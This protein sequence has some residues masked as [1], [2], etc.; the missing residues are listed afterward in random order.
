MTES[1]TNVYS[2][3]AWRPAEVVEATE[4]SHVQKAVSRAASAGQQVR[5]ISPHVWSWSGGVVAEGGVTIVMRIDGIAHDDSERVVVGAGVLL[6]DLHVSAARRGLQ[7]DAHGGCMTS[8]AS[9]TAGGAVATNVHHTGVAT[10][11]DRCTFVDIVREDST[12]VRAECG[13]ELWRLTVGGAGRTGVIVRVGFELGARTFYRPTHSPFHNAR[14]HRSLGEEFSAFC[15]AYHNVAPMQR[16]H[17][18]SV[19]KGLIVESTYE[20][21]TDAGGARQLAVDFATGDF[22]AKPLFFRYV[23]HPLDLLAEELPLSWYGLWT[24]CFIPVFETL[25]SDVP[26]GT[27]CLDYAC[28]SHIVE[29]DEHLEIAFFVPCREARRFGDWFDAWRSHSR[30]LKHV[31]LVMRYVYG[32]DTLFAGNSPFDDN[33]INLTLSNYHHASFETFAGELHRLVADVG[34]EFG[35]TVRLH[36]G[37]F[38]PPGIRPPPQ[39]ERLRTQSVRP[40]GYAILPRMFAHHPYALATAAQYRRTPPRAVPF[41]IVLLGAVITWRVATFDP[42]YSV[43]EGIAFVRLWWAFLTTMAVV[44]LFFLARLYM[45]TW[46]SRSPYTRAQRFLCTLFV[47]GCASRSFVVRG[48]VERLSLLDTL[49]AV[50]A[51]GRSIATVAEVSFATQWA[52][53]LHHALTKSGSRWRWMPLLLTPLAVSAQCFS[54]YA[55]LTTHYLFSAI[56]EAHWAVITVVILASFVALLLCPRC[57]LNTSVTRFCAI[58]TAPMLAWLL[59]LVFVDVPTYARYWMRDEAAGKEYLSLEEGLDQ[60]TR[61]R[62]TWRYEGWEHAWKWMTPYFVCGSWISILLVSYPNMDVTERAPFV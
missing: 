43:E 53:L 17:Y 46:Y 2:T 14:F 28:S 45:A 62:V 20:R 35:S 16:I 33:Y 56:E 40:D 48:D 54:W 51:I 44:N 49:F 9:Q 55:A 42:S 15:D 13:D 27:V 47:V 11:A 10:F 5:A 60:I 32:S 41:V 8:R 4:V 50:V 39:A 61:W 38:D 26:S 37:K 12:V 25:F 29:W 3:L 7:L 58:A 52:V 21:T 22:G 36:P 19:L 31:G 23:F 59:F 30:S 6:A 34:T 57:P 24:A 18:R 1:P